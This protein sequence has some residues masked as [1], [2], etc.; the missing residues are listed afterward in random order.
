MD[1]EYFYLIKGTIMKE[2][3]ELNVGN[4][5]IFRILKLHG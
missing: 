1:N 2:N 3:Q 5:M 4:F